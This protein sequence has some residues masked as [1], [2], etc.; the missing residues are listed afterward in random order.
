MTQ[1]RSH[2]KR[3]IAGGTKI[4]FCLVNCTNSCSDIKP[5]D[6]P[7]KSTNM[8]KPAENPSVRNP[9]QRIP[10]P[11]EKTWLICSFSLLLF[12]SLLPSP[13]YPLSRHTACPAGSGKWLRKT[14]SNTFQVS[15]WWHRK[16]GGHGEGGCWQEE[17]A[18]LPGRDRR[19]GEHSGVSRECMSSY[20][21]CMKRCGWGITVFCLGVKICP[22]HV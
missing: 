20:G 13:P 11:L 22:L 10:E 4:C 6:I 2:C 8:Q 21:K 16:V 7:L 1:F 17:H 19:E 3:I 5:P 15:P 14:V 12:H 9:L 18:K